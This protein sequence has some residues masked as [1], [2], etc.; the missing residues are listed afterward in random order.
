MRFDVAPEI[1]NVPITVKTGAQ[2]TGDL[3]HDGIPDVIVGGIGGVQVLL[4]RKGGGLQLGKTISAS[5]P[6]ALALGDLN[7]DGNPDLITA[8]YQANS[9]SVLLGNG[10]GSFQPAVSYSLKGAQAVTVG[11]FNRDGSLDVAAVAFSGDIEVFPGNGAGALGQPIQSAAA[12]S[13]VSVYAGDFNHDGTL[14]LV[15]IS[16]TR[17]VFSI[18][19]GNGDGTFGS[20]ATY[21]SSLEAFAL[22]DVNGDGNLDIVGAG[23]IGQGSAETVSVF[24]GNGDGTVQPPLISST[25]VHA[26]AIAAADFNGDG[27]MD[28]AVAG[29]LNYLHGS[30]QILLGN[31]DGTFTAGTPVGVPLDSLSISALDLNQDGKMDCVMGSSSLVVS[32]VY[33][34]GDGSFAGP[35]TYGVAQSDYISAIAQADLNGDGLTDIVTVN[36]TLSNVSVLLG[37]PSGFQLSGTFSVREEP[38]SIAIADFNNDGI[39]DIVNNSTYTAG[40]TLLLGRGDGTF[41]PEIAFD[42]EGGA[43]ALAAGD[44]NGDGNQDVVAGVYNLVEVFLGSGTGSFVV[45]SYLPV[46]GT[47]DELALV[48]FTG[49]GKLDLISFSYTN[50]Y[51][52]LS[53][54]RGN[55]D[56]TFTFLNTIRELSTYGGLFTVAD[57]NGDG[58]PDIIVV[59]DGVL[60][61]LLGN[62]AGGFSAAYSTNVPEYTSVAACDLNGDGIP[63]VAA[64]TSD[65]VQLYLGVGGGILQLAQYGFSGG[66]YPSLILCGNYSG[67][68]KP[69]LVTAVSSAV[70]LL[71]NKTR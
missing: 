4:G 27:R 43:S 20:E 54:A 17:K 38:N 45:K 71:T 16:Q 31:G 30:A 22:A 66:L 23:E 26:Y 40:I 57:M 41:E 64:L 69:D 39:P 12:P 5:D 70:V 14:D 8:S 15:T 2:V 9:I 59:F 32:A 35:P 52:Y 11:D 24:L 36:T 63:D 33:G 65:G 67:Q 1:Y 50:S 21:P 18:L 47:P 68:G 34:T 61:V 10:D 60:K 3:N 56:G 48:D 51:T 13:V 44:V 53:F 7:G 49:D 6:V 42:Q 58:I 29:D 28:V 62:G 37:T 19:L 46:V 55:G 25:S